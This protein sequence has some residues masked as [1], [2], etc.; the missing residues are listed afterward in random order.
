MAAPICSRCEKP[1]SPSYPCKA[2]LC[3]RCGIWV[4]PCADTSCTECV[5]ARVSDPPD[6]L[7]SDE[8][9]DVDFLY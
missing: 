8:T 6:T 3:G 4:S 2:W 5:G 1:C 7:R 9:E